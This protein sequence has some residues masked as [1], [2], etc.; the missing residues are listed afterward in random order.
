M[1]KK[2]F[3]RYAFFLFALLSISLAIAELTYDY[4]LNA[5]DEAGSPLTNIW[6]LN[7]ECQDKDCVTLGNLF[8]EQ[9]SG[10]S[11]QLTINYPVPAPQNGY[12]SYFFATCFRPAEMPYKP[13]AKGAS[14]DN[15]TFPKYVNCQSNVTNL[16]FSGEL[17]RNKP[18]EVVAELF[19]ITNSNLNTPPLAEPDS[20]EIKENFYSLETKVD[21]TIKKGNESK[22][23]LEDSKTLKLHRDE[24]TT[25][26]F[27]WTP[28]EPAVYRVEVRAST[29]DCKCSSQG[30]PL[31][32]EV[33]VKVQNNEDVN[34]D[35]VVNIIDLAIVAKSY[36][37]QPEE[38][39]W[40]AAADINVDSSVN[41][42]D[43]AAVATKF[44]A[45]Y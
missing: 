4:T 34:S 28:D 23:I 31:L 29:L 15:Y 5:F 40:N 25:V 13:N 8:Q 17:V 45:V 41:I 18:V 2:R 24:L 11:N 35:G 1:E 7:Y 20:Q 33:V 3:L 19:P 43:L 44:G 38:A 6:N 12:A 39:N 42:F 26:K 14:S 9:N 16:G 30:E 37:S 22:I 36:G 10:E 21:L 32:T 27:D